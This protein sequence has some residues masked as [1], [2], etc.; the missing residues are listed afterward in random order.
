MRSRLQ[1]FIIIIA[2]PA[3][4]DTYSVCVVCLC[5]YARMQQLCNT[6]DDYF[7]NHFF[8]SLLLRRAMQKCAAKCIYK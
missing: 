7:I 2:H 3:N 5:V 6:S 1:R 4:A 8:V